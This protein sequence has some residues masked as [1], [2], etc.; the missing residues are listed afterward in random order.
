[1]APKMISHN[2]ELSL[3]QQFLVENGLETHQKQINFHAE[4]PYLKE[5]VREQNR[6]EKPLKKQ[7]VKNL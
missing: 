1:M 7:G 4:I 6:R 3:G 2:G 5:T